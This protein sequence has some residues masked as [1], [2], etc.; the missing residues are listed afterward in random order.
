MIFS[1][2]KNKPWIP[3]LILALIMQ[4]ANMLTYKFG[5]EVAIPSTFLAYSFLFQAVINLAA[6]FFFK[7]RGFPFVLQGKMRLWVIFVGFLYLCNE[8]A[9]FSAYRAGGPYSLM[10][11]IFSCTSLALLTLF[12]IVILKEKIHAKQILG[13]LLG[14]FSIYL[15]KLG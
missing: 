6:A 14:V 2:A 13:I 8:L 7:S 1:I 5:G 9:F 11:V 3:F 4:Q 12:A 15:I 10:M